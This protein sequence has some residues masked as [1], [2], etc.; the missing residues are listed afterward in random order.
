VPKKSEAQEKIPDI[1]HFDKHTP[2]NYVTT[3][4]TQNSTFFASVVLFSN[5]QIALPSMGLLAPDH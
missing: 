3:Y 1:R 5:R 4:W 2:T